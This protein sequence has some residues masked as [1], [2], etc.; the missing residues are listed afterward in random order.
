[1]NDR[2]HGIIAASQARAGFVDDDDEFCLALEYEMKM[3]AINMIRAEIRS[4]RKCKINGTSP[5]R[6]HRKG[7]IIG[8]AWLEK[9]IAQG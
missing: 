3:S 6:H 4:T 5:F 8:R 9:N 2:K 7:T 1:M